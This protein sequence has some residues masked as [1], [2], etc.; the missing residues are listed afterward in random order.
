VDFRKLERKPIF[1][2]KGKVGDKKIET[3]VS[4]LGAEEVGEE[5]ECTAASGTDRVATGTDHTR[6]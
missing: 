4:V 5:A 1:K 2:T 6:I 3:V